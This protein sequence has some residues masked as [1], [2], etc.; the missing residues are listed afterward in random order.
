MEGV[1]SHWSPVLVLNVQRGVGKLRYI[2]QKVEHRVKGGRAGSCSTKRR[3]VRIPNLLDL[4]LSS[5][6]ASNFLVTRSGCHFP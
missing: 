4:D 3:E 1:G 5:R 6:S 2:E